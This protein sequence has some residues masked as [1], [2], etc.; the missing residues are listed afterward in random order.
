M[1]DR[2][3]VHPV[4]VVVRPLLPLV[5]RGLVPKRAGLRDVVEEGLSLL[6]LLRV[7]HRL[8]FVRTQLAAHVARQ[9]EHRPLDLVDDRLLVVRLPRQLVLQALAAWTLAPQKLVALQLLP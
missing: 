7:R 3:V 8:A 6:A 5:R 1:H 9:P 2:L 4:V